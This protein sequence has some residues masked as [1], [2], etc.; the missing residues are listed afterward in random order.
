[1]NI[2]FILQPEKYEIILINDTIRKM[3]FYESS[4]NFYLRFI[5]YQN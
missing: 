4:Q 3:L 1:M 5:N 2:N